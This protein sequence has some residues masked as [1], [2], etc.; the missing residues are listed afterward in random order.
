MVR[1]PSDVSYYP[2]T[3]E[4]TFIIPTARSPAELGL[5]D[6]SRRLGIGLV[7]AC[8]D[9]AAGSEE[10]HTISAIPSGSPVEAEGV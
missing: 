7:R 3:I 9:A 6:D 5:S 4:I 1:L 8:L 2:E 10:S